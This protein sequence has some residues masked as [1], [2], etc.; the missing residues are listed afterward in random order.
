MECSAGRGKAVG[1]IYIYIYIYI[2]SDA[3]E[4]AVLVRGTKQEVQ[5]V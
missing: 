2:G 4:M 1:Y 5:A 3:A